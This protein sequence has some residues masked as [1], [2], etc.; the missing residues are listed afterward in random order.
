MNNDINKIFGQK[1]TKPIAHLVACIK[2]KER[3]GQLK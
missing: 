3:L 2:K 1:V